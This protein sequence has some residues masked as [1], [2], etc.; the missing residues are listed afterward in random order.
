[1][2]EIVFG[3]GVSH[4]PL[5]A[6]GA[7][8]WFERAKGDMKSKALNLSDGRTL[9]YD[10]LAAE[11][12]PRYATSATE[13]AFEQQA[14]RAQAALER[15]AQD[16]STAA[17]DVAIVVGDDQEELFGPDNQPAIAI[18][19]GDAVPTMGRNKHPDFGP[20]YDDVRRGYAMERVHQFPGHRRFALNLI[21]GLMDRDV[22]LAVSAKVVAPELAGFGHAFGFVG[23]RLAMSKV[24]MVPLLLNTYYPPNVPSPA[25]CIDVGHKVAEVIGSMREPLRV[26]I[27]ASG[28]LSHFVTDEQLDRSVLAALSAGDLATLTHASRDALNSGSSE[29]LNWILAGAALSGLSMRWSEYLPVYRTPAGTGIGLAF[30]AWG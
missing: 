19:Y 28:G 23:R 15:V 26:A 29:I 11:V 25:R 27:I 7:A 16:L 5:L 12:G 4:S 13:E 22:D 2:A 17:P 24:P 8:A 6:L 14:T 10:A 9:S 21:E 20:W 30:A 3:A 1:M 18:Y